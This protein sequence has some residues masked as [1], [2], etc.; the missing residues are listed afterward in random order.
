MMPSVS[1]SSLCLMIDCGEAVQFLLG[2]YHPY[3]F[4]QDVLAQHVSISW[5]VSTYDGLL[6]L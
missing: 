2:G 5:T 6:L 3:L 1:R 4:T